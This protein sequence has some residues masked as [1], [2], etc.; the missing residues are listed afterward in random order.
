MSNQAK[1]TC[2]NVWKLFGPDEKRIIKDLDKNLSI[3]EV[4]E[5]TGIRSP[6][7]TQ[8]VIQII[9]RKPITAIKYSLENAWRDL[10][11]QVYS[12][13]LKSNFLFEQCGIR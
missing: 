10:Y 3:K 4:Q 12:T 1:I 7:L 5:K 8:K 9:S 11:N 13:D 2:T 6:Q